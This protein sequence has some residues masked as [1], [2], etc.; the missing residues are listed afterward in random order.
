MEGSSGVSSPLDTHRRRRGFPTQ[1]SQQQFLA[2]RVEKSFYSKERRI[3]TQA[4]RSPSMARGLPSCRGLLPP[5]LSGS[6]WGIESGRCGRRSG[7]APASIEVICLTKSSPHLQSAL[8]LHRTQGCMQQSDRDETDKRQAFAF[9][10]RDQHM[11][12]VKADN[13]GRQFAMRVIWLLLGVACA[14]LGCVLLAI[15]LR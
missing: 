11:E 15:L 1:A 14:V 4:L 3:E 2:K 12:R 9:W 6:D 10:Q 8:T 7:E 5:A 13:A